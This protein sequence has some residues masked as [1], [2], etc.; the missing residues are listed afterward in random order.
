MEKE[1]LVTEFVDLETLLVESHD[2]TVTITLNR[3][4]KKN[5]MN[6]KMVAELT[7]VFQQLREDRQ[8]RAIVLTGAEGTFC[9]GGDIKEMR[10]KRV[11]ATESAHNLDVMLRAVN[12][13]PQVVIARVEGVALGGGLGLVCVSDVAIAADDAEFGLP[14]VRLGVAP[15]YISPYV[16]SRVTFARARELML[17][18]RRFDGKRAHEY[19]FVHVA[20]PADEI[21][22]ALQYELDE[23]RYCAP[24]AIAAIKELIFE[25][26]DRPLDDSVGYRAN[27]LN[28]LRASDEAQEGLSAFMEKRKPNWARGD[29]S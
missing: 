25:V 22:L 2:F 26:R 19:G 3:P 27:L 1:K 14:E 6:F 7:D 20:C 28:R 12:E 11:P 15:A 4:E 24:H 5:A 8:V 9:A 16:L 17:T 18:G 23:I 10:D 29:E 21:D 13:A